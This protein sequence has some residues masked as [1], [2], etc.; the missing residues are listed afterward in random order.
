MHGVV[1]FRVYLIPVRRLNGIGYEIFIRS[2]CTNS[3]LGDN[4]IRESVPLRQRV[5]GTTVDQVI[6][7]DD[8]PRVIL[9]SIL[10][11]ICESVRTRTVAIRFKITR[12]AVILF[13]PTPA[14]AIRLTRRL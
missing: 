10:V 7:V 14:D 8:Q 4:V 12:P 2:R 1:R 11:V 13:S 6:P 5:P 3:E 9:S